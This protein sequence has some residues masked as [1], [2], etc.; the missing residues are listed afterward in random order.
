M[1]AMLVSERWHSSL[2][3]ILLFQ[4][5]QVQ[6]PVPGLGS[7]QAPVTPAPGNQCPLLA[8]LG[9]ALECTSSQGHGHTHTKIHLKVILNGTTLGL[10]RWTSG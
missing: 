3:H 4:R 9:T 6:F 5:P 1:V 10:W 2:E 8:P 7:S